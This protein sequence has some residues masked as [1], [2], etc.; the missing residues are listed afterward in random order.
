MGGVDRPK[1]VRDGTFFSAAFPPLIQRIS[2]VLIEQRAKVRATG[3]DFGHSC[4]VREEGAEAQTSSAVAL[5]G[6]A[7][8]EKRAEAPC[9]PDQSKTAVGGPSGTGSRSGSGSEAKK[10]P[11]RGAAEVN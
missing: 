6:C 5:F 4:V 1:I 8:G 9:R 3:D 10:W 2:D 7:L 11:P